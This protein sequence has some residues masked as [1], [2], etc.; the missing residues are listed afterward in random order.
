PEG[1]TRVVFSSLSGSAGQTITHGPV[2]I[3][4]SGDGQSI[5][6]T[7]AGGNT[8][9]SVKLHGGAGQ[10]GTNATNIYPYAGA[11][12][13]NDTHLRFPGPLSNVTGC[14]NGTVAAVTTSSFNARYTGRSVTVRWRTSSEINVLGFNVYRVSHGQRV[15]LNKRLVPS[16]N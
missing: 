6:F 8:A 5:N 10:G 15:K 7:V 14:L 4:I 1:T 12:V 11:G 3:V 2:T 13:A 9:K 16:A